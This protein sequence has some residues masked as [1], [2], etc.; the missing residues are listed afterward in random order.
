MIHQP[1]EFATTSDQAATIPIG[2]RRKTREG[3]RSLLLTLKAAIAKQSDSDKPFLRA[4]TCHY[5][6]DNQKDGFDELIRELKQFGTF[7][8]ADTY[9]DI[10]EGRRPLDGQYFH[11][12]FDDGFRNVVDNAFPILEKHNVPA[13]FFVP[14]TFIDA[15]W[16]QAKVFCEKEQYRDV[17][18]MTT[19]DQ[20]RNI[21]SDLFTVGAHTRNHIRAVTISDSSEKLMDELL[22][23][24]QDIEQQLQTRCD[25]FAW[26][27]G[28]APD[29]SMSALQAAADAGFRL[30]FSTVRET[31]SP[32]SSEPLFA[33]RHHFEVQWPKSHTMYFA[34]GNME[35]PTIH[36]RFDELRRKEM[37]VNT[38]GY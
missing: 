30:A 31:V 6:F 22:G 17:V 28:K 36:H 10:F 7:I 18:E 15:D 11:L 20:L 37:D 14:T 21:N 3:L 38:C 5:V 35:R 12:S 27:R 19:W 8:D 33:P 9:A 24:K 29:I 32:G 2:F 13:I 4:L 1:N 16:E 26:P 25:Y 23:S 34:S